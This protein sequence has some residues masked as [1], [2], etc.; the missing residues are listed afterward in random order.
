METGDTL[1]KP[2]L[3]NLYRSKYIIDQINEMQTGSAQPQLPIKIMNELELCLPTL[4]EQKEIVR[5]LDKFL[6]VEDKVKSTCQS[7]LEAIATMRKSILA[8]AFRGELCS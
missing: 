3:I 2:F 1:Y 6:S 4:L 8:K 5:L 7:T